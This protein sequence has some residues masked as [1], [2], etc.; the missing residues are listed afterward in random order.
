M[1]GRWYV[2]SVPLVI[3]HTVAAGNAAISAISFRHEPGST[4]F[5][6]E[7]FS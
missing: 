6:A 7:H 3:S 5:V 2:C 4:R 1:Q